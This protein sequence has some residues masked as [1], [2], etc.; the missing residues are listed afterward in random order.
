MVQVPNTIYV[1]AHNAYLSPPMTP[2][3]LQTREMSDDLFRNDYPLARDVLPAPEI[4]SRLDQQTPT[5][6]QAS[7]DPTKISKKAPC[8]FYRMGHC[9]RGSACNFSH[10]IS[11]TRPR[12][13]KSASGD[14]K[15]IF[16]VYFDKYLIIPF[17]DTLKA[18]AVAPV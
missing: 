15:P 9:K 12:V 3:S 13:T 14:R 10:E 7:I 17:Q 5:D 2:E 18:E 6:Q 1:P 4:P 8:R 16:D 11:R